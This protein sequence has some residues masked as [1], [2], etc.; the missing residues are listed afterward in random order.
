MLEFIKNLADNKAML[1]MMIAVLVMCIVIVMP[2][3]PT[4]RRKPVTGTRTVADTS[5]DGQD[6]EQ[7][8]YVFKPFLTADVTNNEPLQPPPLKCPKPSIS[9]AG[10][11]QSVP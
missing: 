2:P 7:N 6:T 9:H 4:E 5:S 8:P 10:T 3:P 1:L 11:A